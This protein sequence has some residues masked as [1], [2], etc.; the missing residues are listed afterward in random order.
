MDAKAAAAAAAARINAML[1]A[2]GVISSADTTPAA[3]VV[4]EGPQQLW[5]WAKSDPNAVRCRLTFAAVCS[6]CVAWLCCSQPPLVILD[7]K[8]GEGALLN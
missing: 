3:P 7:E 4:K 2:K 5:P 8:A 1:A 6:L